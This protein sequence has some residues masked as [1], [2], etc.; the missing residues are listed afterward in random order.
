MR[1]SRLP[2]SVAIK[3]VSDCA[4]YPFLQELLGYFIYFNKHRSSHKKQGELHY[5]FRFYQ[6]NNKFIMTPASFYA[7]EDGVIYVPRGNGKEYYVGLPLS[8]QRDAMRIQQVRE[9]T[10][11]LTRPKFYPIVVPK[12]PF[13]SRL[14]DPK[15]K[16]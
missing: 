2:D 13:N 8:N 10:P 11:F 9:A 16:E 6:K 12:S 3:L 14:V 7:S 4:Q 1:P 5:G 15:N